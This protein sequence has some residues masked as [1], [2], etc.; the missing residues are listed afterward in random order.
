MMAGGSE[1]PIRVLIV[2]DFAETRENIRKL[3]Q[4]ESDIEVVGAARTGQEALQ[5][6]NE[7]EPDVVLMD[8][9]MPDMD[10][11]VATE[12]LLEQVPFA[13]IIILSVQNEGDYVRR[14]MRAGA[15]D[16]IAKPPS[17]DELVAAIRSSAERARDQRSKMVRPS[18]PSGPLAAGGGFAGANRPDGK[19]ITVYS[20]KGGVGCTML[21]TNFALGLHTQDTPT[22]L[23]DCNLQFGDVAVFL[24]LQVKN[25]MIDLAGRAEE[26]D[27]DILEE[28]LIAHESGLRVLA[29]PPRPEMADEIQPDQVRKVLQYLR[30][31]FAYVVVDTT[32]SMEDITLAVLD[33]SDV[34]VTV[35]TPDIPAI[36]DARLLMDLLSVLEFPK[37]KLFFVMNKMERKTGITAEAVAENLKHPVDG[38]IPYDERTVTA[39]INRGIPLLL[40]DKSR[41]PGRNVLDLLG[42]L[43]QRLVT[44]VEEV[45]VE[46]Q[47]ERPKLFGR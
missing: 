35:A 9:N 21:A 14:A 23:V 47:S 25:S 20:A 13:Q 16:F 30:R 11:I 18:S 34:L 17:G 22:V 6:A 37:S 7:L 41:P 46:K 27:L 10:G 44:P 31:N 8:I 29:A 33:L 39:S 45:E 15:R 24:N 26:L 32:S 42:A 3:L 43:K 38:E 1:S 2:D 12:T 36:K 4:F 40:G 19:V 5:L 28:V